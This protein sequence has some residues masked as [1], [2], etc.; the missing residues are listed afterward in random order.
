VL[1]A[2]LAALP[3][4][5]GCGKSVQQNMDDSGLSTRVRTALLNAPDISAND[6]VV[7]SQGGVITLSG[8][9]RTP[10]ER[11]R[12]VAIARQVNGVS[13]VTANVRVGTP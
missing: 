9:V 11:E 8:S 3:P 5:W 1:A 7:S 6:I 4:A 12:A 10:E 13:D 2:L